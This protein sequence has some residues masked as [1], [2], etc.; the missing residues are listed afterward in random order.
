MSDWAL[1]ILLL[2]ITLGLM[3]W[4]RHEWKKEKRKVREEE[5]GQ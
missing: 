3:V 2:A 1:A 5:R 4:D